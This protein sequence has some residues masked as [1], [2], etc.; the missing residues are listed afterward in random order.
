[1]S[2]LKTLE[3]QLNEQFQNA[4]EGKKKMSVCLENSSLAFLAN[5]CFHR[6][7]VQLDRA[8]WIGDTT[9]KN[10]AQDLRIQLASIFD[11]DGLRAQMK[12]KVGCLFIFFSVPDV[13]SHL[14]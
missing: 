5:H 8:M 1:M 9:L 7:Q 3:T 14:I 2:Q 12:K 6:S 11:V 13:S 10:F 4:E